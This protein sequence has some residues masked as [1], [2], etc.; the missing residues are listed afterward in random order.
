ML[1][2][3]RSIIV[4]YMKEKRPRGAIVGG[5]LMDA[6]SNL[7]NDMTFTSGYDGSA[8]VGGSQ[9]LDL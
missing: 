2:M 7:G 3:E 6:P 4:N 8:T 9:K 1:R 5:S